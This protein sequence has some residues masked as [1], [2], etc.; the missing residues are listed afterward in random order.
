MPE[1]SLEVF[2][3]GL[4]V[5]Q[6]LDLGFEP[7]VYER[8]SKLPKELIP[9]LNEAE[10]EWF[11]GEYVGKRKKK[12]VWKS[13]RFELDDLSAPEVIALIERRLE[14]LGVEPKLVPPDEVLQEESKKLL[15]EKVSSWFDSELAEILGSDELK[16][17]MVEEFEKRFKL[18]G[19]K[20]WITAAF[21]RDEAQGWR[22]GIK[23]TLQAAYATKHKED[24][25]DKVREYVLENVARHEDD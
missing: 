15:R 1:H 24:F 21:K 10:R 9:T 4:T 7:E 13:K 3:I 20:A 17:K 5:E 6:V 16:K 22:D 8:R 18:K 2:D 12:E 25:K 14:E 11:V 19:A 23:S